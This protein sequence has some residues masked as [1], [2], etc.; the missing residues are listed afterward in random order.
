MEVLNTDPRL[1]VPT[2][3]VLGAVFSPD[4]ILTRKV[5]LL[6]PHVVERVVS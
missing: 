1:R 3:T 5:V 4:S 2:L 6:L